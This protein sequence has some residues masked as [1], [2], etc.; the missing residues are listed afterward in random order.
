MINK[1][2][3]LNRTSA[4]K[5]KGHMTLNFSVLENPSYHGFSTYWKAFLVSS[6][7]LDYCVRREQD[8]CLYLKAKD[9]RISSLDFVLWA[10]PLD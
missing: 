8:G 9:L 10:K 3:S 5:S 4:Y 6:I 1:L 7:A 2:E